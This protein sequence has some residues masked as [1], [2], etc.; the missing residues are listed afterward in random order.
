MQY[1]LGGVGTLG[2]PVKFHCCDG[3]PSH[4]AN[5][6]P[7]LPRPTLLRS[8]P[9]SRATCGS[10]RPPCSRGHVCYTET[11]ETQRQRQRQRQRR[12]RDRYR[13]ETETETETEGE[14]P[15]GTGK[16]TAVGTDEKKLSEDGGHPG[17]EMQRWSL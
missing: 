5:A 7:P 13:G 14:R 15:I 9:E 10:R 2:S 6:S 3:E 1:T 4:G 17:T 8:R 12:D 16:A 11:G